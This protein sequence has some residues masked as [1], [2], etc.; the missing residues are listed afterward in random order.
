MKKALLL[1][2]LGVFALTVSSAR[3]DDFSF[4]F[5]GPDVSHSTQFSFSGSGNIVATYTGTA[6]IWQI[7]SI[8]GSVTTETY[9]NHSTPDTAT[10]DINS[11]LPA[12]P[13]SGS[14]DGN[15]NLLY[16]PG[17]LSV[18]GFDFFDDQGVSFSLIGSSNDVNLDTGWFII[19]PYDQGTDGHDTEAIS[20]TVCWQDPGNTSPTPEPGSLALL[21]TSIL[22]GAGI[23]RRR[24]KA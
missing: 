3:A 11:L 8:T 2:T 18:T 19:F 21:G 14:F 7:D 5:T 22:G 23:L 1:C 10:Y 6:D 4:S 9:V 15:D 17:G 20:E 24:F 12:S 13:A 16:Y